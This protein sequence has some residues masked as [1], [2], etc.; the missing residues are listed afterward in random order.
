MKRKYISLKILTLFVFGMISGNVFGQVEN[1]KKNAT[2][3]MKAWSTSL[4]ADQYNNLGFKDKAEFDKSELGDPYML[5]TID[6]NKLVTI[7]EP[8][9]FERLLTKTGNAVFTVILDGRNKSLLWMYEKDNQWKIA[10]MGSAGIAQNLK[11]NEDLIQKY[12]EEKQLANTRPSLVRVY[13]LYLDFFFVKG[14]EEDFIVPMQTIPDLNIK[15]NTFYSVKELLPVLQEELKNKMPF[16][17]A[18]GRIKEY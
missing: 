15:G 16:K 12:K 11:V 7:E 3:S 6:P 8:G 5:L 17:D 18:E 10:R 4:T 9:D 13:Q 14:T 1:M 2:E